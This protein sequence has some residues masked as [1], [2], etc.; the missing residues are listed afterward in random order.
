MINP[1]KKTDL[2]EEFYDFGKA[3]THAGPIHKNT[4]K[5]FHRLE[6]ILEIERILEEIEDG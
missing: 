4:L 5:E 1:W 6:R 2:E 3:T